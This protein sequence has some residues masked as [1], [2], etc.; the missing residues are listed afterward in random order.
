MDLLEETKNTDIEYNTFVSVRNMNGHFEV[1]S[2]AKQVACYW[3]HY[4]LYT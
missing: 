1:R 3:I 2:L 4:Y